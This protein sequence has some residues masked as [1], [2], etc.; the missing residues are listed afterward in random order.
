[1]ISGPGRARPATAGAVALGVVLSAA[2][3]VAP[4]PGSARS[5]RAGSR[6][7]VGGPA[8]AAAR[9]VVWGRLFSPGDAPLPAMRVFVR[10]PT[11]TDS[12]DVLP[13]GHFAALLPAAAGDDAELL[14]DAADPSARRYHPSLLR[15]AAGGAAEE[16]RIVLVPRWWTIPTGSYAGETVDIRVGAAL[17]SVGDGTRFWRLSRSPRPGAPAVVAWPAGRLPVPVAF[18]PSAA[19]EPVRAADSAA[20]WGIVRE[21]ERDFGRALFRP[22]SPY[23]DGPEDVGIGVAVDPSLHSQ[24]LTF[25]TWNAEGDVYDGDV[26]FRSVA[27]LHDPRVVAHEMLHALGL[28]HTNAWASVM[29][30]AMGRVGRATPGDVAYGQLLF[31]VRRAQQVYDAPHAIGEAAD[32]ERA[33]GAWRRPASP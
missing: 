21:L 29:S 4:E 19:G 1:M 24:G 2:L 32:G 14:V 27:L 26:A 10:T 13:S 31:A 11:G 22:A 8:P 28:G 20:F 6:P 5:V 23:R 7:A 15:V 30:N 16:R 25:V 17:A 18:R 9:R 12:T 33:A 3:G